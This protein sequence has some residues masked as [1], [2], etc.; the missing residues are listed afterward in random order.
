M[1]LDRL[2]RALDWACGLVAALALFGIMALTFVDVAGRKLFSH[3]L[4]GSLE[5]TEI[6]MVGVIFAALPL[7]SLHAEHVVFDSLDPLLERWVRRAQ[8]LLVEALCALILSGL[9]WLMW[10]KAGKLALSGDTT[11]QLHL[12][13]GLFVQAMSVL[14]WLS[15][16]MHVL[17][18]FAP[19]AHH[20]PG[21]AEPESGVQGGGAA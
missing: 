17:R 10:A 18:A 1:Y 11:A 19:E 8:G 3:S 9:G 4:P 7:V 14:L 15:A 5:L 16:L 2:K 13:L 12:P 20:H 21:V 6:L